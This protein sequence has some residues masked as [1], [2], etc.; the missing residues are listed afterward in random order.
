MNLNNKSNKIVISHNNLTYYTPCNIYPTVIWGDNCKVG[1][2]TEI[3]SNVVIGNNVTIGAFCF[4]PEGV[5][6]EDDCWIGPRVTFTNDKYPP[7]HREEWGK[8]VVKKGARLGAAVTVICGVKIGE[9]ALIG[10]GSVVTKNIPAGETW[11][12]VPAQLSLKHK[13]R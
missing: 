7:S 11:C 3:G 2:F 1:T 13:R 10:A 6:I 12:G 5:T 9:G 4:I 8:T